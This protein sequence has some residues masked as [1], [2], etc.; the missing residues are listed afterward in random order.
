MSGS[1]S[2]SKGGRSLG[3]N[4]EGDGAVVVLES[5]FQDI[6]PVGGDDEMGWGPSSSGAGLV[7]DSMIVGCDWLL[8]DDGSGEGGIAVGVDSLLSGAGMRC[9]DVSIW[10]DP[11]SSDADLVESGLVIGF[12]P[13]FSTAEAQG[14]KSLLGKDPNGSA[15]S[16]AARN[17]SRT[18][19]LDG[20]KNGRAKSPLKAESSMRMTAIDRT[21]STDSAMLVVIASRIWTVYS[22]CCCTL[23]RQRVDVDG[24]VG[25]EYG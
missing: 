10:L 5:A 18:S 14:N 16:L 1:S 17:K 23:E 12:N 24:I 9:K 13:P 21:R 22:Q 3:V 8:S 11:V 4:S 6:G 25:V 7:E 20:F 2:E 19:R 15:R